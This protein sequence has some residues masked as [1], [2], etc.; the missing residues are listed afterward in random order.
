MSA[1]MEFQP[2]FI[3]RATAGAPLSVGLYG[4]FILRDKWRIGGF[5]ALQE[6]AG[7]LIQ[8]QVSDQLRVGYSF[9]VSTNSLISTNFGS[10]EISATYDFR[11]FRKRMV[12]P[13][14]F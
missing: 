2:A 12:Y 9:D 13:R 1:F 11:A 8:L 5:Y 3:A 4:S 7:A 10:H 6:S 14:R